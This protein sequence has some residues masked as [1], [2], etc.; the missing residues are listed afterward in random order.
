VPLEKFRAYKT[1]FDEANVVANQFYDD[2]AAAI[3][4]VEESEKPPAK[5]T[6]PAPTSDFPATLTKSMFLQAAPADAPKESES[7]AARWHAFALA[8]QY[9]EL[10]LG[11]AEEKPVGQLKKTVSE[12]SSGVEQFVSLASLTLP[13]GPAIAGLAKVAE[14]LERARSRQEFLDNLPAGHKL[15]DELVGALMDDVPT[16]YNLEKTG[17]V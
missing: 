9:N 17:S 5:T 4:I 13:I 2:A 6:D 7:I 10:M 1:A 16:L 12:I 8:G 11:L 15:V 3:V 14:I